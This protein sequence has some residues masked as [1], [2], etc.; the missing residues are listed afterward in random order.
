MK[1]EKLY[2]VTDKCSTGVFNDESEAMEYLV[3]I[4]NEEIAFRKEASYYFVILI[5]GD[6]KDKVIQYGGWSDCWPEVTAE[7]LEGASDIILY[8]PFTCETYTIH[9]HKTEMWEKNPFK[10]HI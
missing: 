9:F 3:H 2:V 1:N 8:E 4:I 5:R 6:Q 10:R 7:E